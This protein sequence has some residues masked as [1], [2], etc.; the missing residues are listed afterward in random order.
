MR[1]RGVAGDGPGD[2][3]DNCPM[4]SN[5]DQVDSDGDGIGDACLIGP[6]NLIEVIYSTPA[7]EESETSISADL[8]ILQA[9]ADLLLR[10]PTVVLGSGFRVESGARLE[11]RS[12]AVTCPSGLP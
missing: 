4:A 3:C 8:V 2:A 11:I 12:E 6:V 1:A 7:L 10:A 9:G 5:P